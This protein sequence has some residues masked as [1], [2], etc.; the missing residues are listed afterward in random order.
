MRQRISAD[1]QRKTIL[2]RSA[3]TRRLDQPIMIPPVLGAIA[4]N[5]IGT[6]EPPALA[7][8]KSAAAIPIAKPDTSTFPERH[9]LCT[10]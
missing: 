9:H 4:P 3:T 8:L 2:I 5:L 6:L 10:C 7:L 1:I